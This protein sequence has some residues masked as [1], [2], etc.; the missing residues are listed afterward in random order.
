MEATNK[1]IDLMVITRELN[2]IYN[3]TITL[4]TTA[5]DDTL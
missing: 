3:E 1:L 4:N 2:E 5:G